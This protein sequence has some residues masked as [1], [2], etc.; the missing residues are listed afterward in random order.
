MDGR[1]VAVIAANT[2][3]KWQHISVK[4]F[5][6]GRRGTE[7]LI[8]QIYQSCESNYKMLALPKYRTGSQIQR[9]R[10]EVRNHAFRCRSR[11][12]QP[13]HCMF[14]QPITTPNLN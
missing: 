12:A 8:S 14:A 1:A 11:M 10:R 9:T 7:R 2:V 13:T 3:A 4:T 6:N 5:R